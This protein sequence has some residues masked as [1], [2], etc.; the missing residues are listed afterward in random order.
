MPQS[1]AETT[2]HSHRFEQRGGL[3]RVLLRQ[4]GAP[5]PLNGRDI[6]RAHN[7]CRGMYELLSTF[8][9]NPVRDRTPRLGCALARICD[10]HFRRAG[11]AFGSGFRQ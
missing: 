2:P 10:S 3:P 7:V 5:R 9:R 11:A 1:E 4:S 8:G 6:E